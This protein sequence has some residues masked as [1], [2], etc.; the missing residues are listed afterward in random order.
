[1]YSK[2]EVCFTVVLA[3]TISWQLNSR[4]VTEVGV[5][6]DVL[7]IADGTHPPPVPWLRY[8]GTEVLQ[9]DGTHPPPVP[10]LERV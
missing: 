7:T 3:L 4:P 1:M 6:N 5:Q 8:N 2:R 9:A 10:W